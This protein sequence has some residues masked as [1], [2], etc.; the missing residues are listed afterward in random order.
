MTHPTIEDYT[1]S[2]AATTWKGEHHDVRYTIK[3]WGYDAEYDRPGTWC[4]YLHLPEP[5]WRPEDWGR[6]MAPPSTSELLTRHGRRHWDYDESALYGLDWHGGMTFFE[7]TGDAPY[8]AIKAGCDY[9]HLWDED[10][11]YDLSYVEHE[12]KACVD[13]LVERFT[14]LVRCRWSGEYGQP[15]D[16]V[17]V[18]VGGFVL[19]SKRDEIPWPRWFAPEV[20]S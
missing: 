1:Q 9:A 19:A 6:F 11:T 10:V 5:Q 8:R 14:P 7:I 15:E 12:A 3:F 18:T 4:F 16:M 17:P 13:S 20:A 2:R